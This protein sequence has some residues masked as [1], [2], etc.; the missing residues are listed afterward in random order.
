MQILFLS[1][2][3]PSA[4][5]RQAGQKTSYHVCEF[6]ARKH[7][8]HLLSFATQAELSDFRPEDMSLFESFDLVPVSNRTRIMGL[9][10]RPGLPAADAGILPGDVILEVNR[11]AVHSAREAAREVDRVKPG[12]PAFLLL[13]RRGNRVFV[14]MRRE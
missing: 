4:R 3:L 7:G 13:S 8:V 11:Q 10:R 6:L 14:E 2:H 9:M 12:Q 1:A 5:A